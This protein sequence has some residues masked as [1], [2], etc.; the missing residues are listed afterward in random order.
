M[1]QA[2]DGLR[3]EFMRLHRRMLAIVRRGMKRAKVA[4]ART[5]ATVLHRLGIDESEFRF[6]GEAAAA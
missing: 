1:V 6:G 3:A 5:L 2:R 4:L